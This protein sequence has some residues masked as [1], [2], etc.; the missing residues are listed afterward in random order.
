MV[1][2]NHAALSAEVHDDGHCI[3][4]GKHGRQNS[5]LSYLTETQTMLPNRRQQTRK[6]RLESVS[7]ICSCH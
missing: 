7:S 3:E 2:A 5:E 6:G 4:H 1:D